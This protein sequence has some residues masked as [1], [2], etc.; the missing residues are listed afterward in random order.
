[1]FRPT[2]VHAG[3]VVGTWG[4]VSTGAKRRVVA[5]P[6]T[7]FDAALRAAIEEQAARLP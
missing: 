2:V 6:F 3:R 7:A 1:M 5:E 4:R